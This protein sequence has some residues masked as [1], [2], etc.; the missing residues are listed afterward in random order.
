MLSKS[1]ESSLSRSFDLAKEH[2]HEFAT[3]EHLLLGLLEDED[4]NQALRITGT[5]INFLKAKLVRFIKQELLYLVV[6]D[7]EETKPTSGFQRVIHRATITAHKRG[8]KVINGAQVVYEIFNEIDSHAA[9]FLSDQGITQI[10]ILNYL[11][12]QGYDTNPANDDYE[13]KQ[14]DMLGGKPKTIHAAQDDLKENTALDKYCVNLNEKALLDKIDIVVGRENEVERTIEILCRRTKNNP[15]YVGEPGVGKTAIAEG[16]AV[17]IVKGEVPELLKDSVIYSLDVGG[18]LAGTRFRGDFEERIKG[19]INELDKQSGAILFIDEI[20]TIVGAGSS[21]TGAIDAGN[22]LKPALA[23]GTLKC[24]GST[25]Y[26]EYQQHFSKDKALA[27]RFQRIDINEPSIEDAI[28]MMLGLKKYYEQFHGVIYSDDAVVAA[29]KLSHRY[30]NDRKLP[31]KAIDLIDEIGSKIKLQKD[32]HII[33]VKDIEDAISRMIKMP[34]KSVI[35]NEA[36]MLKNMEATLKKEVFGQDEAI[37]IIVDN[38]K[39]SK[40]GLRNNDK[41]LGCYLFYGPTGVG[42]TETAIKI[43]ESLHMNLVRLD[44]SEFVE[45]HSLSKLVGAPPGYVG[46]QEGGTLTNEVYRKPYSLILLDEIEKAHSDIYNLLLQV[47]DYGQLT[48]SSGRVINFRNCLV[49]M[50]TNAGAS[51]SSKVS[52]GFM[53]ADQNMKNSEEIKKLFSPEFRNRL[54]LVVP[55]RP[56]SDLSLLKVIEKCIKSLNTQLVQKSIEINCTSSAKKHILEINE[57]KNFGARSVEHLVDRYIKKPL[58]DE[59]LFGKLHKGGSAKFD[60]KKDKIKIEI[61]KIPAA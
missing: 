45:K 26:V 37:E 20:H 7:V 21:H 31:D 16:L 43:A 10:D 36:S 40:A 41:P 17:K 39:M 60:Y 49:M 29:V 3:L 27:R 8:L 28:T 50:T 25:T 18:I 30:I 14:L 4:A 61:E 11:T 54:D 34:S 24:I 38:I 59:I 47:M 44:M 6:S 53:E 48:D 55:F 32:K 2:K 23:R 46:H 57:D 52:I 13:S 15:I 1:L 9:Y 58:V 56:L 12:S 51:D 42:K 19:I 5:D 33:Q 22:L 35:G